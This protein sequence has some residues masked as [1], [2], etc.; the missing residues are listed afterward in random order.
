MHNQSVTHCYNEV[1][2][3]VR[4]TGKE[5]DIFCPMCEIWHENNSQCQRSDL[6]ELI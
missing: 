3:P 1:Q 4:M 5:K 2:D 6:Y